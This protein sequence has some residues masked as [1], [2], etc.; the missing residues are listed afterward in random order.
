[1]IKS[2]ITLLVEQNGGEYHGTVK[3]TLPD[4]KKL[5]TESKKLIVDDFEIEFNENFE[6][7]SILS[8]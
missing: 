8:Q 2:T 3:I 7:K 1:M 4:Y 6:I 5:S